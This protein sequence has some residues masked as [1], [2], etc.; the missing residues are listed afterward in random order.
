MS[1]VKHING[2]KPIKEIK[3]TEQNEREFKTN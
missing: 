3:E 1:L 2:T